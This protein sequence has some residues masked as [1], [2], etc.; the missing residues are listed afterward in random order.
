ML[1]ALPRRPSMRHSDRLGQATWSPAPPCYRLSGSGHH[2]CPSPRSATAGD[3]GTIAYVRPTSETRVVSYSGRGPLSDGRS[4]PEIV[5]LGHETL[6]IGPLNELLW[7][8]GT[9]FAAPAVA[10]AAALLNA[11]WEAQGHETDPTV[12]ENT[13]LLGADPDAVGAAW[14]GINDQGYGALGV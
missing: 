5:S 14:Q 13:L 7:A 1:A 12:L 6:Y 9:S 4:G 10:G 3:L 2:F 11:W 8:E